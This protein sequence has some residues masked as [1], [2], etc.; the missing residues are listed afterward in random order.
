MPPRMERVAADLERAGVPVARGSAALAAERHV[1]DLIV[2]ADPVG[3][4]LEVFH[5]PEIA[6]DPF[7]PGRAISASA[8]GRSAWATPC[9]PPSAS[10]T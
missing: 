6:S 8:P 2:F 1:T 4:R 10:T 3:N 7:M 9:S 5:G